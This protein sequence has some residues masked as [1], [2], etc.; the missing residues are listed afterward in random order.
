MHHHQSQKHYVII[1]IISSSITQGASYLWLD[2]YSCFFFFVLSLS[3]FLF[4]IFVS[5]LLLLL[6]LSKRGGKIVE[7]KREEKFGGKILSQE[8]IETTST[9][10]YKNISSLF[11][12]Y[13]ADDS[14]T[15]LEQL[16]LDVD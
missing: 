3:L 1:I 6:L 13:F 4:V 16:L 5:L 2:H 15:P 14:V 10:E 11:N 7:Q 8:K 9:H 12:F